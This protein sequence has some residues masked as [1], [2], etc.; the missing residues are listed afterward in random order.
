[1]SKRISADIQQLEEAVLYFKIAYNIS[2][3]LKYRLQVLGNE[4][5]NDTELLTAPEYASII[6]NYYEAE[7]EIGSIYTFFESLMLTFSKVPELYAT[8]DKKNAKKIQSM[9][10]KSGKYQKA[11]TDEQ[12][13][14]K[15]LKR[16]KENED[17]EQNVSAQDLSQMIKSNYES[18]VSSINGSNG[19]PTE[20]FEQE[21]L[22]SD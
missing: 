12:S 6:E 8:A 4:L 16:L 1:M 5:M 14:Q 19:V 9:V 13:I 20:S 18:M 10:E 21:Q 17:Q 22:Q 11:I 15:V 2:G 7:K 3:E